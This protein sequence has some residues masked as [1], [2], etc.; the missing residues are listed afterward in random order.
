MDAVQSFNGCA[1]HGR[2]ALEKLDA[3]AFTM[4][5]SKWLAKCHMFLVCIPECRSSRNLHCRLRTLARA[6]TQGNRSLCKALDKF[7]VEREMWHHLA[8]GRG[9]LC[10]L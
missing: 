9:A 5:P 2:H 6:N 7:N 1:R 4:V 8:E 3:D 10:V